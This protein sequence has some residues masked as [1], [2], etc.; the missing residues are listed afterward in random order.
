[1]SPPTTFDPARILPLPLERAFGASLEH[2]PVADN[3]ESPGSTGGDHYMSLA[4]EAMMFAREVHKDQRRKYTGNPYT[5]HLAEVAG[6]VVTVA[7]HVNIN[8]WSN[9][10]TMV[11]TAWLHDCREDQGVTGEEIEDRFGM[12]VAVGVAMLSDLETGNRAAR[13]AASR[14]RLADAPGW[15]QTIKC[16]DLISNTASI[17]QHDPKFAVI[18]LNEKRLLLEV[19]TRADRRLHA[20]AAAQVSPSTAA[21]A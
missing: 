7:E 12:R 1:M 13:K 3:S 6:I 8:G 10:E 15:V 2:E 17:V 5:D 9:V 19:L 21:E 14:A 18:Y 20:L 11:A 16:A 4:Y